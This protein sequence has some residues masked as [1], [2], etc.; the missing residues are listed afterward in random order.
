MF[1]K[2]LRPA[3]ITLILIY[4]VLNTIGFDKEFNRLAEIIDEQ[5][6][7]SYEFICKISDYPIIDENSIKVYAR[8]MSSTFPENLKNRK[9][10]LRLPLRNIEE[11]KYGCT[12]KLTGCISAASEALNKGGFSYRRYMESKNAVGIF[13]TPESGTLE[14]TDRAD[15]A[16]NSVYRFRSRVISNLEKYFTG[17]EA[18]LIIAMLTGERGGISEEMNDAYKAAGIFHIVSVSGLHA[19]IFISVIS[20]ALLFI[21]IRS[22]RKNLLIRLTAVAIGI[23]LYVFTGF[24]ISITRVIFMMAIMLAAAMIRREY[25]I[26]TAI[27]AA[28][29][30]ILISMP[31]E[32]FDQSF[33]LTFL[34][35]FG[36]CLALK[37]TEGRIPDNKPG[38]YLLMPL[39]ISIGATLATLHVGVY[40]YRTVS[41]MG[42]VSNLIAVPLS[43]F[44]LCAIV[45][46]SLLALILPDVIMPL[47]VPPVYIPT[48]IINEMSLF[49]AKYKYSYIKVP[50]P[51]FFEISVWLLIAAAIIYC[52]VKKRKIAAVIVCIF[53]VVNSGIV[54][55]NKDNGNTR[56]TFINAGKGESV[57]I[58]TTDKKVTVIDCGSHSA[59]E[60]AEDVFIPY[61]DHAGI[62]K[63]DRL[64]ISY[65]DDEHT[66]GVTKLMRDGYVNELILPPETTP[67]RE[68]ISFNRRKIIDAA[69]KFGVE[70][71]T[72]K[73]GDSAYAGK[74]VSVFLRGENAFLSD[75]NACPVY[76]IECGDISFL[77]S[78]CLG[79][80]GQALY[81]DIPTD[82]TVLKTPNYGSTVKSTADYILSTKPEYAVITFPKNDRYLEFDPKLENILKENNIAYAR[83]DENQT[84]TFETDGKKITSVR[85]RKGELH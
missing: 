36:L 38:K 23:L 32:I 50:V 51:Q 72:I 27:P 21:P 22:R 57:I 10:L 47:F 85:L 66:N 20:F 9:L 73:H 42:I 17:D 26:L 19:G 14:C 30:S 16:V 1:K 59:S 55:Y 60:P 53:T 69:R 79:A 8:V 12:V 41:V 71:S 31:W 78:S 11:A 82:C 77:L 62:R 56:V 7:S 39:V 52:I 2:I 4:I 54:M 63:I 25:N 65:F 34:S 24:G 75:K 33:Q 29:V 83:T 48:K 40:N 84:I 64:F 49:L 15:G 68:N 28:A 45:V 6:Q 76:S 74:N 37:I 43:S 18:G 5:S 61:F 44:Q 35:T 3:F 13:D 46:F 70:Y 67:T 80:K 81:A 58:Q